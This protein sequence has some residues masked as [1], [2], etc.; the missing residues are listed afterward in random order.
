[1][2]EKEI[3]VLKQTLVPNPAV[4]RAGGSLTR[5]LYVW[6][7]GQEPPVPWRCLHRPS[8]LGVPEHLGL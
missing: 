6:Y 5:Q 1:M 2:E 7:W 8:A 4:T 3:R